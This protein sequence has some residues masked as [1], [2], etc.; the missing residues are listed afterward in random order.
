M[1][2]AAINASKGFL[3]QQAYQS[4]TQGN[5]LHKFH[6]QL[7]M[8]RSY[9]S[10]SKNRCQLMLGRSNFVMLR[11]SKHAQLPQLLIQLLHKS[12]DARLDDA[13]IMVFHL[14]PFR[15][16]G[17]EQC[18]PRIY[19]ILTLLPHLLIDEEIFLL[20]PDSSH[21]LLGRLPEQRQYTSGSLVDTAHRAQQRRF[22]IQ[23]FAGI[24]AKRSRDT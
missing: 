19:Q 3:V 22:F 4:V 10:S 13:K 8:I 18:A 9:V 14:L 16:L 23:Y 1:L 11:F 15:N 12:Q 21:N 17:S 6:C 2:T 5:A 24:G 20:R 7:I